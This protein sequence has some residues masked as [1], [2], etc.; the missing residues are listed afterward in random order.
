[1]T[2]DKVIP[3]L[4]FVRNALNDDMEIA[5]AYETTIDTMHRYQKITEIYEKFQKDGYYDS[6]MAWSDVKKV[7][8]N[9]K[10]ERES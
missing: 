9:G 7:V 5:K 2:I 6:Y 8:E 10:D 3:K 4:Q 1:M